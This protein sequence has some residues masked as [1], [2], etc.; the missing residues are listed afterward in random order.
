MLRQALGITYGA[1]NIRHNLF[2]GYVAASIRHIF[3]DIVQGQSGGYGVPSMVQWL[4]AVAWSRTPYSSPDPALPSEGHTQR[5]VPLPVHC[6]TLVS[7]TTAVTPHTS[8]TVSVVRT[9]YWLICSHKSCKDSWWRWPLYS[10]DGVV[11]PALACPN[12]Q[13]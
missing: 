10:S 5:L 11:Q 3:V 2:V 7:F 8:S 6:R 1:A 4:Y 12:Q 13:L 9:S